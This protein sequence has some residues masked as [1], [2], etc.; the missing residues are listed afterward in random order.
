MNWEKYQ[1]SFG[2]ISDKH[3][4]TLGGNNDIFPYRAK[5]DTV[6]SQ[7]LVLNKNISGLEIGEKTWSE[8]DNK[9][10]INYSNC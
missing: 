5:I 4:N 6:F 1:Y 10:A 2:K 7:E 3:R 9:E 8:K